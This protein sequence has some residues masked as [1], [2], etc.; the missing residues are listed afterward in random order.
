MNNL[1]KEELKDIVNELKNIVNELKD[2]NLKVKEFVNNFD[3]GVDDADDAVDD[4]DIDFEAESMNEAGRRKWKQMCFEGTDEYATLN[5][6]FVDMYMDVIGNSRDGN[7]LFES[8]AQQDD[9]GRSHQ[10]L[11]AMVA[12]Y[13]VEHKDM[14]ERELTADEDDNSIDAKIKLAYLVDNVDYHRVTGKPLSRPH[15]VRIRENGQFAGIMD[16][17]V[18]CK[19]MGRPFIL[20]QVNPENDDNFLIHAYHNKVPPAVHEIPVILR[21]DVQ[22]FETL[23]WK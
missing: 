18:L 4:A 15:S 8:V 22:H 13:Y 12:N 21:Y 23:R 19:L 1:T 2:I 17:L 10:R 16:I 5:K 7:C 6:T 9:E 14:L 11:R 20:L 3:F